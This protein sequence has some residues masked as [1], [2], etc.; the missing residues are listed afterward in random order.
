MKW[1]DPM[2]KIPKFSHG[3]NLFIENACVRECSWI[4]SNKGKYVFS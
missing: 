4:E 1:S 2:L 3:K